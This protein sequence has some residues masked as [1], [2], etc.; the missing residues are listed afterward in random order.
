MLTRAAMC[1]QPTVPY[2]LK[3]LSIAAVRLIL[4]FEMRVVRSVIKVLTLG[5]LSG[6]A[7]CAVVAS[8]EEA[9]SLH[10]IQR[11][12]YMVR[13][14]D[15]L[16]GLTGGPS[17]Q[18]FKNA[19]VPVVLQET[20]FARQLHYLEMNSGLDC[21]IGMF[22]KPEREKF[23]RYSKPI[24]QDQPHVLLT[25]VANAPRFATHSSVGAVFSDKALV[26][27]V[28]LGYSYGAALDALIDRYQPIHQTTADENLAMI[29]QIQYGMADYILMSPEEATPAIEAAGLKRQFF[30][31]I[32]LK[33]M[34][35]GEFRHIMCSKNVSDA[36]MQRLNA[37][38]TFRK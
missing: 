9:V 4:E 37:A 36:V 6:G 5:V 18:A 3:W 11:P 30:R 17:Y 21:M 2:F 33:D 7:V 34:P 35:P 23:A 26:L 15:G 16:T 13:T 22:K 29:R 20:P 27:L 25:S 32:P 28:K 10:Y 8:A 12:P 19:K 1:Q 38:I 24:Y 31:Q 14:G